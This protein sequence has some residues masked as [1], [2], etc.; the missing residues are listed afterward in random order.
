MILTGPAIREAMAAGDIQIDPFDPRM[1]QP[2]G[3]DLRMGDELIAFEGGAFDVRQA[4][5]HGTTHR[6]DAE[7]G[8]VLQ[9]GALYLIATRETVASTRYAQWL[10]G[11]RSCGSMGLWVQVSAPLGHTGSR[12]RW[13]LELRVVKP[14]R[15]YAGMRCCKVCF[16]MNSGDIQLY[17][18]EHFI[19]GK[20]LENRVTVSRLALDAATSPS[21]D[22]GA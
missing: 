15:I 17:G 13:T 14:L 6:L 3:V 1:I 9:P 8:Y 19:G 21:D 10:F 16:L 12:I 2:N 11:D 20:Y 4:P 7:V 22:E 5:E 18:S